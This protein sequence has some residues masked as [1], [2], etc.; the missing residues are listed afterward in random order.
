MRPFNLSI[1]LPTVHSKNHL[2]RTYCMSHPEWDLA[3][4][5][6]GFTSFG[7]NY[8]AGSSF[9]PIPTSCRLQHRVE[10]DS[11]VIG[12]EW[13]YRLQTWITGTEG[14]RGAGLPCICLS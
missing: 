2:L 8:L 10:K 1:S 9:M 12:K 5:P 6:E 13:H 4:A 3:P 14:Q 7:S 11:E